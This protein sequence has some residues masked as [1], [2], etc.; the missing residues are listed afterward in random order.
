MSPSDLLR[1][2]YALLSPAKSGRPTQASLRRATSSAYYALFHC[3][4]RECAD[5]LI[6]GSGSDRS[7][8]A[9]RVVYRALEHGPAKT[10]CR[11]REM[12]RKFPEEVRSFANAFAELQEKRH[13]VDYDPF[14][15]FTKSD[16]STDI[17]TVELAITAF[18]SAPVKDRR[19]FCAYTL[20]KDRND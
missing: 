2:A 15:Q 11:K 7:D 4:A 20:F 19:A 1:T 3:L 18:K 9:W 10:K 13:S 6:G 14:V 17:A 5:L 12:T 16:A 8:A